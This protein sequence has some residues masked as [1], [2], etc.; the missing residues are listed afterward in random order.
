MNLSCGSISRSMQDGLEPFHSDIA[1]TVIEKELAQPLE[2]IYSHITPTPVAAASLGQVYK[3]TLARTG[4]TVAVKV[5]RPGIGQS[6]AIDMLL[7][8]QLLQFFDNSQDLIAQELTP[9]VDE[10]ASRLFGELDYVQ[11]GKNCERFTELYKD[12][13]RITTPSIQ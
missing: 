13:P 9:L 11:E 5:Q 10:F 2:Q 12:V 6:I 4:E 7:L 3:A 1:F 8:R